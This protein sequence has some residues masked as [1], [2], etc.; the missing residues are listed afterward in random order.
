MSETGYVVRAAT[1][2]DVAALEVLID[3]SVRVL[4]AGYYTPREIDAGL[5]HVFG[6]DTQLVIDGTYYLVEHDGVPAACGGWSGRRTLFGGDQHKSGADDRLD[7]SAAPARIR[8]FFVHPDY[9]RRGLGR[10]LYEVCAA[11]ARA[12]GF[13]TLE[14]MATLPG[15]PLYTA[16]GFTSHEPVAVPTPSG[17]LPCVRMTR[18]I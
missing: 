10:R 16:L 13:R 12:A 14:L 5:R 9:A 18:S 11:A 17:P 6:V 4:G 7:P 15:V 2:A 8:A 1:P 3:R